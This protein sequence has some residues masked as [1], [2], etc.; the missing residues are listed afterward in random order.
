[1]VKKEVENRFSDDQSELSEIQDKPDIF[2]FEL[3]QINAFY[4]NIDYDI[5]LNAG[6]KDLQL[7]IPEIYEIGHLK[8]VI[9]GI[10]AKYKEK[11][12]Q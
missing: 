9:D 2:F 1:M 7:E 3:V 10:S 11:L 8:A 5:L 12:M 6:I 4:I